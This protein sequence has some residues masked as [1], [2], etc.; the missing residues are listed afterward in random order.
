V[1]NLQQISSGVRRRE[2]LR[3]NGGATTEALSAD[4]LAESTD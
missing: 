1:K 2:R 3:E 4:E